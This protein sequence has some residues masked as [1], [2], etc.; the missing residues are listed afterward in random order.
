MQSA[1]EACR[2]LIVTISVRIAELCTAWATK[3]REILGDDVHDIIIIEASSLR[4][5][6]DR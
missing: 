5:F 6:L 3:Y 1:S 4:Q 2:D